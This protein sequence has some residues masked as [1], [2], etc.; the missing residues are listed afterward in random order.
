MIKV[1]VTEGH[2]LQSEA[3]Q[4]MAFR[5][6]AIVMCS[7]YDAVRYHTIDKVKYLVWVNL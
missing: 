2:K 6:D 7:V 3:A 1:G 5:V 4:L